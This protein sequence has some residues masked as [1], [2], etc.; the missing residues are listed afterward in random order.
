MSTFESIEDVKDIFFLILNYLNNY[1]L[2]MSSQVSKKWYSLVNDQEFWRKKIQ[3]QNSQS[4]I[5]FKNEHPKVSFIR[6]DLLNNVSILSPNII[7]NSIAIR[8]RVIEV[9]MGV[10]SA[11]LMLGYIGFLISKGQ[12]STEKL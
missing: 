2:A 10:P 11:I 7:N 1:E 9:K 6:T 8:D 3:S 5:I 12:L 4:V